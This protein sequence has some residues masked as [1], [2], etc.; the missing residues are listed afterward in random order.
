LRGRVRLVALCTGAAVVETV[1]VGALAPA[2]SL[3][4]ATQVSA[5]PPFGVF[6]DL[7]WIVVYHESWLGL[8]LELLAFLV[9]RSALTALCLRGAWPHDLPPEPLAVTARRSVLFTVV[10]ALLLAP[11]AALTFALAVV[12]LSWLF[13]VAVPVV[14]LLA[15]FVH[16]GA[17]TGSWWRRT[18]SLRSV[19]WVLVAFA[20][21][22]FFGSVL[23][24][25]PSWAR[26]PIAF[27][28]GVVNAWLWVRVVDA[29]LRR[30]RA[31]RRAPVAPVGVVA[32]LALVAVGTVAGF[33][34][35]TTRALRFVTTAEAVAVWS[36]ALAGRGAPLVVV[37]GFDTKWEGR[38]HPY[39]K[40]DLP[41]WRFSYRGSAR[42]APLPYRP[43]DTHR[44]FDVLVR[45]LARQVST[46]HELTGREIT[47]VAESEGALLAKA[48]LG[49]YPHA[50]VRNL[51]SL[52]PLVAPGRVY[53]PAAGEE[54][55]GAGGA[56]A[57][58][59]FA[60]ALG[61]V[62]PVHVTPDAP[63]LRSIVDHAP[64]LRA[65]VAC[66]LPGVREVAV[67][68]LDTAVSAP[69]PRSF[70][71]EY[72]VVPGFHGGML[73][74]ATTA[75]VVHRV[76]SGRPVTRDEGWAFAEEVIQAG[77]S[78]WQVPQLDAGVN[79]KWDDEP[80]SACRAVR[81][82]LSRT[83]GATGAS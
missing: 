83:F 8:A 42:G 31:P 14:L 29:V 77:A 74:D 76:V 81:A 15:L 11:W 47:L 13:F 35:S 52:S 56:L 78:A 43:V 34:L 32:V 2:S 6:H 62:S 68:P 80:T 26:A 18:L 27:A 10:V 40:I 71:F 54:G 63:F 5:P 53:Y 64:A 36:P 44:S 69:A 82:H 49:A 24:T 45:E 65:L 23:T 17:V 72:T 12:S 58:E 41:Q 16:G 37:T 39:V 59:S 38:A 4:L 21:L 3:G 61:G 66:R 7:R 60:W 70:G 67:L 25:C 73:D 50:P 48:Y 28:A 79:A 9:F 51:V 57:M 19:G 55:W 30:R 75:T 1:L 33:A 22:T 46:Y 20:A